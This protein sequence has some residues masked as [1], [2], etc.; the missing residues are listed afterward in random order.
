MK[1]LTNKTGFSR[2]SSWFPSNLTKS[3]GFLIILRTLKYFI[4]L[5][6]NNL[7]YL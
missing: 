3:N 7:M 5:Y 1:I 6:R 4:P 2:D